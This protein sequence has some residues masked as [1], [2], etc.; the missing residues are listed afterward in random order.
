MADQKFDIG[1]LQEIYDAM[2][3]IDDEKPP[4]LTKKALS[5]GVDILKIIDALT[6]G[7]NKVGDKFEAMD[8]FLPELIM[9][10]GIMDE[11]MAIL[12]PE[13]ER[14][15]IKTGTPGTIVIA[16]LQGDI[17]DIG[18]QIATVMLR[19]AGI[20]VYDL[21]HDVKPDVAIDKAVEVKA[22]VIGLSSLLTTSLPFSRDMINLL[23]EQGLRDQFQVIMGGG[24]VTPEF[25]EEIGANGYARDAAHGVRVISEILA[26]K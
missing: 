10:A 23:E 5:E 25:S 4:E 8:C 3:E 17:H 12:Q 13:L 21:G 26:G 9:A 18:R 16:N 6:A 7:I 15:D 11:S 24:A 19:A 22:D 2:V 20:K 1:V 14:L